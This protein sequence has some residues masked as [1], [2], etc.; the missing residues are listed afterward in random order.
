MR[1]LPLWMA[2]ACSGSDGAGGQDDDPNDTLPDPYVLQ[3]PY[4][5]V[6]PLFE[7]DTLDVGGLGVKYHFPSD[8]PV[9][10]VWVFHG[11]N[12]NLTTIEQEE[13]IVL[14]NQFVQRNIAIVA[15]VSS[16][17][18]AQVWQSDNA[19]AQTNPDLVRLINIRQRLLDEGVLQPTVPHGALG[20]SQGTSM[21]ATFGAMAVEQGWD[22]RVRSVHQGGGGFAAQAPVPTIHIAAENDETG[23]DA[24]GMLDDVQDCEAEVGP[25]GVC[26]AY[27]GQ[28][29]ALHP[30]RFA[31]IQNFS[32]DQSAEMVDELVDF[33]LVDKD[34]NRTFDLADLEDVLATYIRDSEFG[35]LLAATQLRVVWATHR[36]SS[37]FATEEADFLLEQFTR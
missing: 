30:F 18:D 1:W 6:T 27:E 36:L 14:Y 37:E 3:D 29:V 35:A 34:G 11:T 32:Q 21:T 31:R 8:D 9:G 19:D 12:G 20:F 33:G 7:W 23:N 15:T 2:C 28:E 4:R 13:W 5:T 22:F 10:L 25:Q 17:R 24:E 16:D 26:P